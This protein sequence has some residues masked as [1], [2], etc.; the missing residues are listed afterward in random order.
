MESGAGAR[1][2]AAI[3]TALAWFGLDSLSGFITMSRGGEFVGSVVTMNMKIIIFPVNID[4]FTGF[5]DKY[6]KAS[7]KEVE[8]VTDIISVGYE[9]GFRQKMNKFSNFSE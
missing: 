5:F 8:V 9:N 2:K 1:V 6:L 7:G 4:K 3:S